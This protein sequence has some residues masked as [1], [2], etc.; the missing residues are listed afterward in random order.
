MLCGQNIFSI[1]QGDAKP[2]NLKAVYA[3][4]FTP[5]DLTACSEIVVALPNADG[6]FTELSLSGS[7]VVINSPAVLGSFSVTQAAIGTV[8]DDL[9]VGELQN[10]NV[11]FTIAGKQLTVPYI[12]ALSVFQST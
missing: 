3:S 10:F 1:F 5:L 6:T 9:N 11:V 12:Q 2:L 4:S 8:S 7:E